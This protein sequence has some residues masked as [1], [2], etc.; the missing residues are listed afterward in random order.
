MI[1][2]ILGDLHGHIYDAL[3]TCRQWEIKSGKQIDLI[4]QL[5]DLGV[6]PFPEKADR[7]TKRF[8]EKDP[9]ELGFDEIYKPSERVKKLFSELKANIIFIHGNHEDFHYLKEC[10][11]EEPIFSVEP[12][13]R[14]F[15]LKNGHIYT[16]NNLRIAGLGGLDS[17]NRPDIYNI[18]AYI[19]K[20]DVNKL[21][22]EKFDILITHESPKDACIQDAGSQDITA[23]LKKC[24]PAFAF[25]AHYSEGPDTITIPG[26]KTKIHHVNSFIHKKQTFVGMLDWEKQMFYYV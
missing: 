12:S 18:K 7:A 1:I 6:W 11:T 17:K 26:C 9:R 22:K 13:K 24:Q 21:L 23:I 2:A 25:F 19:Q 10:S 14:I 20:E 15:C 4:L 16:F 8:A 5:G 3:N